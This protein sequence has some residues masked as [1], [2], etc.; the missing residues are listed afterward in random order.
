MIRDMVRPMVMDTVQQGLEA[1][2]PPE[3]RHLADLQRDLPRIARDRRLLELIAEAVRRI[4]TR[5]RLFNHDARDLSLVDDASVHLVVTSPPYW[6]LKPYRESDG[7]LGHVSDY[8]EFLHELQKVWRHTYRVLVPGGRLVCV[9]GDVCL[10]RRRNEGRHTV[11]PLHASIQEQCRRIGF[12]NLAPIIW[13]KIA[14]AAYEVDGAGGFL[15][16]PYEPNSVIKNDIEFILM[17]RKPGAYRRPTPEARV[18]SVISTDDYQTWFRQIWSDIGGASTREHPAPFPLQ[19]AERL[20]RMF[21]FA[22]DTVLDPFTGTGTTNVAAS[23]CARHSLGYEVDAHYFQGAAARL[24]AEAA[25]LFA[26]VE[27][28]LVH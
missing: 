28:D 24:R 21:S 8:E 1:F 18:L 27:V 15:G 9:V 12:D 4:P 23:R 22:G 26:S 14:N 10:S 16:K 6:T 19:L 7:Q 20:V 5:H 25:D 2:V 3:L 17:E 13:S 11:V